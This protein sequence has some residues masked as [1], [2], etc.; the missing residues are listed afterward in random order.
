MADQYFIGEFQLES[1]LGE[2]G[3]GVVFRARQIALD[4]YVAL[5]LLSRPVTKGSK[6]IERFHREARAAARLVHPNIIQIYTIGDHKGTPYFA[7]EF[8]D[9]VDLGELLENGPLL[10]PAEAVEVTRSVGKAL[11]VAM[12]QGIVHRDIKPGNIMV[13]RTGLI[14]VMDFGLAKASADSIESLTQEG[15]IV[16]TPTYMSPEQGMSKDLDGRSDLYSLGCVLYEGLTGRPPFLADNIPSII[17]KHLYEDPIPPSRHNPE[18]PE[19]LEA[20]C[21]K[22]LAKQPEDRYQTTGDL[23]AALAEVAV[24]IAQAELSLV[25]RVKNVGEAKAKKKGKTPLVKDDLDGASKA[26]STQSEPSDL[27]SKGKTSRTIAFTQPLTLV[28]PAEGIS[29]RTTRRIESKSGEPSSG[30]AEPPPSDTP[31]G[32]GARPAVE[33]VTAIHPAPALHPPE[34]PPLLAPSPP[35]AHPS[36]GTRLPVP[37][38]SPVP[39]PRPPS[40][41]VPAVPPA[42][43]SG[44]R[45]AVPPAPGSGTQKLVPPPAPKPPG[46]SSRL[47]FDKVDPAAET[48]AL[49]VPPP[50]KST[51]AVPKQE[52]DSKRKKKESSRIV[53]AYFRR[54]SDGRWGYDVTLGHCE[55]AEGLASENLPG[56]NRALGKLGDCLLCANWTSRTGCALATTHQIRRISR[57]EGLPLLEELGAVW[58]ASGRF[59]KAI[60]PLNEYLKDHPYDAAGFRALA[61]VY[62][63]PDYAGADKNRVIILYQRCVELAEEHGGLSD[64]ELKL[65]KDRLEALES[66]RGVLGADARLAGRNSHEV[67]HHFRCFYRTGPI[68]YFAVGAMS[69]DRLILAKAGEIDPDTGISVSDMSNPLRR[70]T[71]FFRRFKGE[72]SKSEEREFVRKQLHDL[73]NTPFEELSK[74]SDQNVSV[75]YSNVRLVNLSVDSSTGNRTV[76][77]ATESTEHELVFPSGSWVEAERCAAIVARITGR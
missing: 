61:R 59:E 41:I 31:P 46:S 51:R 12:D 29:T 57:K 50:P 68:I 64:L 21:L 72:R 13:T 30:V 19:A 69:R 11:G 71:S 58:C 16:G 70:A 52:T 34:A 77:I 3:M 6:F 32:S 62:E 23:L 63:R 67:L 15:Q 47:P 48:R 10:T 65:V 49:H 75:D 14:K 9:G 44:K 73:E 33:P 8:V 56:R 37:A 60:E 40:A 54:L 17:F 4:R 5:K 66:G 7:M 22:L 43:G 27:M 2:G 38:S 45:G 26:D 24:N 18:V 25:G 42:P 76:G 35:P 53:S 1:K 39:P 20:V 74:K 36:S 28:A 55:Y